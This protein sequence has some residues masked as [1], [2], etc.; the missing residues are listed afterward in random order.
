MK[1]QYC[2]VWKPRMRCVGFGVHIEWLKTAN[3]SFPLTGLLTLHKSSYT[4]TSWTGGRTSP[5]SLNAKNKD[6]LTFVIYRVTKKGW[7]FNVK[8]WHFQ[9]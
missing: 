1:N 3:P 9:G 4:S 7:D 2:G 8:I 6:K 5:V